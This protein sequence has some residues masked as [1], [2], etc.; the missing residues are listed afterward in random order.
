MIEQHAVAPVRIYV[1]SADG[2]SRHLAYSFTLKAHGTESIE[3]WQPAADGP[4][5]LYSGREIDITISADPAQAVIEPW[6]KKNLEVLGQ[7]GAAMAATGY[8]PFA[9]E[10]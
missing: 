10:E 9:E 8:N 4:I 7:L 1:I 6:L 5:I 2:K 3:M